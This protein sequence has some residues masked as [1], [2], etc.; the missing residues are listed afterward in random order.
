MI[1]YFDYM[2]K[3]YPLYLISGV[4]LAVLAFTSVLTNRYNR[5]L[6][7]MLDD[8]QLLRLNTGRIHEQVRDIDSM[9]HYFDKQYRLDIFNISPE[10]Q[11]LSTLDRIKSRLPEALITVS[12]FEKK[13]GNVRLPVTIQLN[14]GNY[15][16]LLNSVD[17]LETLGIPDYKIERLY[18][19][20]G[21]VSGLELM[22]TGAL[23]MPAS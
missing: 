19:S 17:Y 14:H 10:R 2:K 9:K 23:S 16:N 7:Y 3:K 12:S 8:M 5:H 4:M 22:L 13:K 18:I 11:I 20:K 1:H 15:R 21:Q 6:S